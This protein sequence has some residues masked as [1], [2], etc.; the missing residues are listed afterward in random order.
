[1]LTNLTSKAWQQQL[2]Q[3]QQIQRTSTRA[4]ILC[5]LII[6]ERNMAHSWIRIMECLHHQVKSMKKWSVGFSTIFII[7]L[8]GFRSFWF[9]NFQNFKKYYI[10][11]QHN[12]YRKQTKTAKQN[13][14]KNTEFH[15]FNQILMFDF[16]YILW[17]F[18]G[19][20]W[21]LCWCLRAFEC[22][23]NNFH[24]LPVIVCA[25]SV[26]GTILTVYG[27]PRK[28]PTSGLFPHFPP[29][30]LQHCSVWERKFVARELLCLLF[31][32]SFSGK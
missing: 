14:S 32:V 9:S 25:I 31:G 20:F 24:Q 1:M 2:N 17:I 3:H 21:A 27:S 15:N 8:K 12:E 28:S 6:M 26:P 10:G 13:H 11:E 23:I 16:R 5:L 4:T 18:L 19:R 22:I 29:A 7:N 30:I